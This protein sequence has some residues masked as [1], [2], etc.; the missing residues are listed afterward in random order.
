MDFPCFPRWR[1]P[2]L[3]VLLNNLHPIL[4]RHNIHY[5][6]FVINQVNEEMEDGCL[7]YFLIFRMG[8]THSTRACC[9]TLALQK[10]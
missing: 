4:A 1:Y 9:G 7:D 2:H 3:V 6:I 8:I 5:R 10:L